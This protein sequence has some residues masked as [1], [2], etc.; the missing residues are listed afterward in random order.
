M[1]YLCAYLLAIFVVACLISFG[2]PA[3]AETACEQSRGAWER[4]NAPWDRH[5]GPEPG[6]DPRAELIKDCMI[7]RRRIDERP[8]ASWVS[9]YG[10][11][12]DSACESL[13]R[14]DAQ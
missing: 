2:G 12:F 1:N 8:G 11:A 5:C 6:Q 14:G 4:G 3:H 10:W 7:T 13:A 9:E